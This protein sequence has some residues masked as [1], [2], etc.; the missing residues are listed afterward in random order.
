MANVDDARGLAELSIPGTHDSGANFE[1][2][3]GLAKT[4]ELTI[5]EQLA[6]GVRY[7]DVRCRHVEDQFLIYHGAIDQN[8]SFDDVLA[9]MFAFLDDHPSET[10]IVSIKEEAM[11]DHTTRSFEDTFAAYVA[12]AP[13]RWDLAPAVPRL[14]DAR[15]KLVLLRRFSATAVPLGIDAAPWADSA[16]FSI[17]NG[18]ASLRVQDEYMVTDNDAKWTAITGLVDEARTADPA[19]LFLDYTSGFQTISALPNITVVSTDIDARLDH[20]L[21]DP[22]N[23]HA[24]LGVLVMDFVTASR[25]RAI[26]AT[27]AP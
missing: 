27:N 11:S 1:P 26:I 10:L 15:G 14:G 21:A 9:S 19:T 8:Q 18:D 6:A 7:F 4:Q 22:G 20:L 17:A 25:A 5:A 23:A 24:H 16:T 3:A 2:Y 13:E 12:R